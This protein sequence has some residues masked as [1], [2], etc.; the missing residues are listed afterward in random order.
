MIPSIMTFSNNINDHKNGVM[1]YVIL[2][3]VVVLLAGLVKVA[4]QI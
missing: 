1:P 4:Y 2:L 3:I